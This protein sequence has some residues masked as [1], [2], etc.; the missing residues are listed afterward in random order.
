MNITL[1]LI[2]SVVIDYHQKRLEV[3]NN[4]TADYHT[5][6]QNDTV[7]NSDVVST[8]STISST[9]GSSSLSAESVDSVVTISEFRLSCGHTVN[10]A[11]LLRGRK[12]P[13][14]GK[15]IAKKSL[16]NI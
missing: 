5:N 6:Y 3:H 9:S 7:N 15:K 4:E 16:N 2:F 11:S 8:H 10:L 12:C 14:C 13:V 1:R